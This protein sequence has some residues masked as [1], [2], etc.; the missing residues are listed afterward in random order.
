M[1]YTKAALILF[2]LGLA[3][4]FV[5]V[6]VGGLPRLERVAS[7]LMALSLVGLPAAL[8]VD[9]KAMAI[10]AWL[11]AGFS[12]RNGKKARGKKRPAPA[13]KKSPA[14]PATRAPR[15]QRS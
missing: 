14:R 15:R 2:G 11:R 5:V 3:L 9:G 1:R 10:A 12:R 8:I 7:T 6:V 13:R 4:G